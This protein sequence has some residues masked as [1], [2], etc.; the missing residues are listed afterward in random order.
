MT[1]STYTSPCHDDTK[2]YLDRYQMLVCACGAVYH[3]PDDPTP[4]NIR[5]AKK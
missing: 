3:N 2:L 1:D 5:G 4:T